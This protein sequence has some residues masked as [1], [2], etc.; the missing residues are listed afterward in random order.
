MDRRRSQRIKSIKKCSCYDSDSNSHHHANK[1][2]KQNSNSTNSCE[3]ISNLLLLEDLRFHIFTFVPVKCLI[4]S[5][6]Y[7]CKDWAATISNSQ[8]VEAY[9]RHAHS[10]PGLYVEN[11]TTQGKSYF[12]EFKDDVNGQFKKT[13]FRTPEKMGRLISTCDGILLLFS[14]YDRRIFVVNPILKCWLIIPHFPKS[15]SFTRVLCRCSIARVP[16]TSKFKL[17]LMD[18]FKDSGVLWNVI[19][20]LRIGIDNSWKE[21]ARKKVPPNLKDLWE[22][23]YNGGNDIYW[24]TKKEVI[25]MDVDKERILREYP[26]PDLPNDLNIKYLWMKNRLS[27]IAYEDSYRTYQIFI[28]D[29][30]SGQWSLYH[31]MEPFD[32]VAACGHEL[33]ILFV[34]FRLWI[35]DQVIFNVTVYQNSARNLYPK[36]IHFGYNVKTKQLTKIEGI[37]VGA[38]EVWLHNNSLVSFPSTAT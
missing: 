1:N 5:A 35:N 27:C 3:V 10:K 30:D 23:V 12:L 29:F 33:D 9:E 28:L 19:Y 11:L 26:H 31:E 25:V 37:A 24:I 15:L 20:V 7:V 18:V 36:N 21:I 4:N 2:M 16:H 6:R 17:F 38:F 22:Q 32:Y 34:E 14:N 8:F 13:N